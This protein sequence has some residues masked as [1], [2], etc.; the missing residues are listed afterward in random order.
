MAVTLFCILDLVGTPFPC[1]SMHS[2]SLDHET[3][4]VATVLARGTE[5]MIL[6]K[7]AY[8]QSLLRW[9]LRM[10]W[11]DSADTGNSDGLG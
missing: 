11:A 6:E 9:S 10:D 3:G 5:H 4:E 7:P 2:L 1:G 8:L